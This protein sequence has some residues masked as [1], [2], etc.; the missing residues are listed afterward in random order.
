MQSSLTS[1][2]HE[3]ELKQRSQQADLHEYLQAEIY[4]LKS[5]IESQNQQIAELQELNFSLDVFSR[6]P[7]LH[8]VLQQICEIVEPPNPE[9]TLEK[10]LPL[11][12][13]FLQDSQS[14]LNSLD[15]KYQ[16][17]VMILSQL[18]KNTD[19][20]IN[21]L[22]SELKTSSE[23]FAQIQVEYQQ[24]L[25]VLGKQKKEILGKTKHF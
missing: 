12:L 21:L 5:T 8:D 24:R 2:M 25:D 9:V 17:N 11:I 6:V 14:E 16:N 1:S 3:S 10:I 23:Q 13:R 18:E 15:I 7:T 22:Q 4:Q 20:R 19:S